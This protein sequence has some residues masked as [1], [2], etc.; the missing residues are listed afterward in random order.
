MWFFLPQRL[1]GFE[2]FSYSSDKQYQ[3][4]ARDFKYEIDLAFFVA[5]FG[6]S[7]KEFDELSEREIAFIRKAWE[8]QQ[9]SNLMNIYN[10]CFTAFYN[11][12][13]KKGKRALSPIRKPKIKL[14]NKDEV[15]I[16]LSIIKE[17]EELEG[18]GWI[19][20]IL[21]ANGFKR[22]KKEVE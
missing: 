8:S 17:N 7:K 16:N 1:V 11:V 2:Y 19:D 18:R 6:Y 13:R 10:A 3:E 21:Q 22:K 5:N 14:A 4:E 15:N 20:R 12:N 9:V